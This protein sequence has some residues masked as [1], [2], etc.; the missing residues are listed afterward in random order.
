MRTPETSQ[1]PTIIEQELSLLPEHVQ[2]EYY[3][4]HPLLTNTMSYLR[5]PDT[6][7]AIHEQS[8]ITP[9]ELLELHQLRSLEQDYERLLG[10]WG[11]NPDQ[12]FT[13]Q[14]ASLKRAPPDEVAIR[15]AI[16]LGIIALKKTSPEGFDV[17]DTQRIGLL[18]MGNSLVDERSRGL[19]A[20]LRTGMGKDYVLVPA[21]LPAALLVRK[22]L[23][24][25]SLTP[26]S[27]RNNARRFAPVGR[28]MGITSEEL[29]PST[30]VIH[31]KD[32]AVVSLGRP[33]DAQ[34]QAI[35]S[36]DVTFAMREDIGFWLMRKLRDPASSYQ[37][38]QNIS[39][40][41]DAMRSVGRGILHDEI[42]RTD[43]DDL[44]TL[45]VISGKDEPLARVVS[46]YWRPTDTPSL[47]SENQLGYKQKYK[48][49]KTALTDEITSAQALLSAI[50]HTPDTELALALLLRVHQN[51]GNLHDHQ[52]IETKRTRREIQYIGRNGEITPAGENDIHLQLYFAAQNRQ[53]DNKEFVPEDWSV[54]FN[55]ILPDHVM[56]AVSAA[57]S[58][59]NHY[60][61]K[62]KHLLV[63]SAETGWPEEQKQFEPLIFFALLAKEAG[64]NLDIHFP[65]TLHENTDYISPLELEA[66]LYS[67]TL[68]L[69]ATALTAAEWYRK[70]FGLDITEIP[71]QY[72]DR[73]EK[74]DPYIPVPSTEKT[75]T[76]LRFIREQRDS[77]LPIL[78]D[79]PSQQIQQ[80]IAAD[81]HVKFPDKKLQLLSAQNAQEAHDVFIEAGITNTITIAV[82]MAGR[83]VDIPAPEEGLVI[84]SWEPRTILRNEEQLIGRTGRAGKKGVYRC[85]VS[86]NDRVFRFMSE[87]KQ[88]LLAKAVADGNQR[89]IQRYIREG[90]AYHEHVLYEQNSS[91]ISIYRPVIKLRQR[92]AGLPLKSRKLVYPVWRDILITIQTLGHSFT[93]HYPARTLPKEIFS[94]IWEANVAQAFE[95][96]LHRAL[97]RPDRNELA[98]YVQQRLLDAYTT[99]K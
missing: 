63:Q 35:L 57:Q 11:G 87:G 27:R 69:T 76:A 9:H 64:N 21:F 15:R 78:L 82:L 84:L 73:I 75:E 5:W 8:K 95:D 97:T 66:L 81:I 4:Q 43:L 68:G 13:E 2:R 25:V 19:V 1:Q 49:L 6:P 83:E 39:D 80:Q 91:G 32:Y 7:D 50:K 67:K 93:L 53:Y 70:V 3:T 51:I 17:W 77:T 60:F 61:I 30:S 74:K 45:M 24:V 26:L 16:A 12:F 23:D 20:N 48:A 90:Q 54:F 34:T 65:Q 42:D 96:I 31:E 89:K 88:H 28:M 37:E 22:H 33:N 36:S 14:Y 94:A 56:Q 62:G 18:R 85:L 86:E 40:F 71:P 46:R 10:G 59:E 44:Q 92:L 38:Y 47:D 79:V 58:L 55:D 99:I 29:T 52:I 98:K 72:E 41:I